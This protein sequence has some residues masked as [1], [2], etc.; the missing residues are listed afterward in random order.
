MQSI[1]SLT[2]RSFLAVPAAA[3][4]ARRVTL[5]AAAIASMKD[6]YKNV[7][8]IGT[9]LDFRQP[10]EFT[11]EELELITSQFNVFPCFRIS[12]ATSMIG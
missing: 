7:F 8:L 1:H 10:N 2:R 4:L 3:L 5:S 9:A 11:P 6:A 12:S